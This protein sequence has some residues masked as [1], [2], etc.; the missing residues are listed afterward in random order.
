[1]KQLI[2]SIN[3]FNNNKIE[4][5]DHESAGTESASETCEFE[6]KIEKECAWKKVKH[7]F[8]SLNICN[9]QKR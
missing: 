4:L 8:R 7:L 5:D 3:D 6:S 1:M 2:S 9:N